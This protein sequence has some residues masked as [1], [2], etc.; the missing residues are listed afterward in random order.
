MIVAITGTR[1][2][3]DFNRFC[4]ELNAFSPSALVS[5]GARGTDT[6]AEQY[7]KKYNIPITV[8]LPRFK[9]DPNIKYHPG[10]YAVRN[11]SIVN[12]AD[13][14]IAFWDGNSKGTLQT[15]TYAKKTGRPFTIF[16][17]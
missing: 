8:F 2:F 7:A 3:K 14:V 5:G 1:K 16:Q 12:A 15:I 4:K 17:V 6:L 11:R 13:I 9:T 10:W